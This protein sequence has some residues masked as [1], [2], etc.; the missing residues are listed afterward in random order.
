MYIVYYRGGNPKNK[1][2][3]FR[4]NAKFESKEEKLFIDGKEVIRGWESFSGWYWFA[5]EI[6]EKQDS[7]MGDGQVV[8]NDQMFFGL[9]Q[10]F[11]EEWGYWTL[12]QLKECG[13]KVWGI[14]KK[15]LPFSGRRN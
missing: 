11:E 9:V 5:T 4:M 3:W 8:E 1:T 13:N 10:G 15:N 6:C 14:P 7:V 2:R 12:A